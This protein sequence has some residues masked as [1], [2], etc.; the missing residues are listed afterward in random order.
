MVNPGRSVD[1][2]VE[3]VPTT[4]EAALVELAAARAAL[5]ARVA[6]D[7]APDVTA[8]VEADEAIRFQRLLLDTVGQ[9]IIA[10]DGEGIVLYWNAHAEQLYGWSAAEARGRSI[11]DLI[12]PEETVALGE[13][14]VEEMLEGETW[15]GDHWVR[16]R[17]GTTF[18]VFATS[19]PI[20]D[21]AGRLTAMIS[22]STD[23]SDRKHTEDRAR[24]LS[25]IVE[26][27]S[28]AIVGMT[29][30]R[31]ITSWNSGA[32]AMFGYSAAEIIGQGLGVL[33]ASARDYAELVRSGVAQGLYLSNVETLGVTRD[34]TI[35]QLSLSVS[36]ILD[37]RGTP[38]GLSCIARDIT[39]RV[40]LE[41]LA[42]VRAR[43]LVVAQHAAELESMER[44]E[45]NRENRAKSEFLSRMS[46]EL[47]TPLNAVL[48]FGQ[49]LSMDDLTNVQREN[50]GLIR[51]AGEH[52]LD[53]INDVLD[54]SS[55]EAGALTLSL[56][57][58]D[59]NEVVDHALSLIRPQAAERD[60][61]VPAALDGPELHV[62]ADRQRLLQ[63]LLN[64]LS[65]A[66]K[67]NRPGGAIE[68]RSESSGGTVSLSVA[69]TGFGLSESDLGQIF[70]PFERLGAASTAIEGTGVGLTLSRS[71]SQEMGGSLTAFSTVGTGSTFTLELPIGHVPDAAAP[72]AVAAP[73]ATGAGAEP[74][75]VL[76]IEDNIANI[77]LLEQAMER[78]GNVTLLTAIQ[79]RLG[80]E[81]AARHR[82]DL[83]LL[84]LHLP[85][86]HGGTVLE[87]L[88]ADPETA[89]IPVVVCSGDSSPGQSRMCLEAGAA[90]YLSKPYALK[91][92][93]GLVEGVRSA[94]LVAPPRPR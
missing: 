85:D 59:L 57:P 75:T 9:S 74:L 3:V 22:V 60:I 61:S 33:A 20:M 16:R 88:R 50:V 27:S 70:T 15:S 4:L 77:R 40:E 47:R 13:Q 25:A 30:D 36:P 76:A 82:P 81:L 87:R 91:E 80:L 71:L 54:I 35:V 19:T 45:A 73:A 8:R 51:S 41:R 43:E 46:H 42:E 56:E 2:D 11:A 49:I 39:G 28:D 92:L 68:L 34:G 62:H 64:L 55:I 37:E 67:Y 78:C 24:R 69:D 79:G 48:G 65:N 52:L 17:D 66:V 23:I 84:D 53:L 89:E 72:A 21:D 90:A 6:A 38:V 32:V 83:V 18:P 86:V 31:T 7:V 93:F 58:V 14:M 1:L 26:S 44:D 10:V 63:V 29:L 12:L 94:E 5:Q